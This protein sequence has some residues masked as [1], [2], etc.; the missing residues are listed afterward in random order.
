MNFDQLFEALKRRITPKRSR[1]QPQPQPQP[2]PGAGLTGTSDASASD[3]AST[4]GA[5][6]NDNDV[7]PARRRSSGTSHLLNLGAR[8]PTMRGG[9]RP[10]FDARFARNK[11]AVGGGGEA[12]AAAAAAAAAGAAAAVEAAAVEAGAGGPFTVTTEPKVKGGLCPTSEAAVAASRGAFKDRKA[13]GAGMASGAG[14]GSGSARDAPI[15]AP[16]DVSEGRGLALGKEILRSGL[17][18]RSRV[19]EVVPPHMLRLIAASDGAGTPSSGRW[20]ECV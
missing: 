10:S 3:S 5:N 11:S 15:D 9:L 2:Q 4:S 13:S 19:E 18:V 20:C 6:N 1:P 12:A 7:T 17:E 14:L 8:L 16:E